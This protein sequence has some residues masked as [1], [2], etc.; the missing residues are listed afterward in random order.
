MFDQSHIRTERRLYYR[1]EAQLL[2]TCY[3]LSQL[4]IFK[5]ARY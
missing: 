1:M 4:C 2:K 3:N 5:L